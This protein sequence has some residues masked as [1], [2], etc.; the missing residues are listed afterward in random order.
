MPVHRHF[1]GW[2]GP[3]LPRAVDWLVERF[4]AEGMGRVVV[5]LPGGRAA[6]RLEYLL[7]R[8]VIAEHPGW[9]PPWVTRIGEAT[10]ALVP[11]PRRRAGDLERQLAWVEALRT[12]PAERRSALFVAP[13]GDRLEDWLPFAEQVRA[14]HAE[15]VASGLRFADVAERCA[16]DDRF[17][18]EAPRWR[19]L[20]AVQE[21]YAER[22]EAAEVCD[23]HLARLDFLASDAPVA[24]EPRPLV[25][26]GV[27][28]LNALQR[29]IVERAAAA[30]HEVHALVAA[31]EGEAEGFDEL[32]GLRPEV[33]AER[34]LAFPAEDDDPDAVWR[35]ADRPADQAEEVKRFLSHVA[36]D[37]GLHEDRVVVAAEEDEVVPYLE[38]MLEAAGSSLRAPVGRRLGLTPPFLLLEALAR[39]VDGR[40]SED[41]AELLRHPAWAHAPCGP[42]PLAAWDTYLREHAPG[43]VDGFWARPP[44]DDRHAGKARERADA[45]D[46]WYAAWKELLGPLLERDRRPLD[47]W[48]EAVRAFLLA[49]WRE[50]PV[51]ADDSPNET[52]LALRRLRQALDEAAALPAELAGER[53]RAG[54]FLELVLHPLRGVELETTEPPGKGVERLGWLELPLDDTPFL[55]VTGF[56][57]GRV[58]AVVHGHPFLP[59]RFREW[60]GLDDNR[61]RLARD[62]FALAVL[63]HARERLLLVSGRRSRQGDPWLPSP[64]VFQA[65]SPTLDRATAARKRAQ[66]FFAEPSDRHRAAAGGEVSQVEPYVRLLPEPLDAPEPDD[67]H[68]YSASAL[69]LYRRSPVEYWLAKVAQAEELGPDPRELDHMAFGNLVHAV[70]QRFHEAEPEEGLSDPDRVVALLDAELDALAARHFG[71]APM[72]SVRLQVEQARVR[73]HR[74]AEEHCELRR[75]GWRTVAVEWSPPAPNGKGQGWVP[76]RGGFTDDEGRTVQ[77]EARLGGRIDRI[78]LRG[79]EVLVLDYKTG[80]PMKKAEVHAKGKS[81]VDFQPVVYRHLARAHEAVGDGQV[82][83]AWFHLSD[84]LDSMGIQTLE[85]V[86]VEKNKPVPIP[87]EEGD[88]DVARIVHGIRCRRFGELG[89]P[90][91]QETPRTAA[92][93]GRGLLAVA[94]GGGSAE[95]AE[96]NEA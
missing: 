64:L 53:V 14:L 68:V 60:L 74:F 7:T 79:E 24:G 18:R 85:E 42:P 21:A 45:L 48:A 94:E 90:E 47:A 5:A 13:D 38:T 83:F 89:K 36:G 71:R 10:D 59:Q 62:A 22:L 72:P 95:G 40:R 51:L 93:L 17:R 88:E 23:P 55:A 12:L 1:V 78:D 49:T 29:R 82:R 19:A 63:L 67:E 50:A 11:F 20:A 43:T 73:L 27:A 92:F 8:R 70:L 86:F 56:Q 30:G 26:V 41:F 9:E 57:Q 35:A 61:R 15:L 65:R 39:F 52:R 84:D 46:A 54:E 76:F 4:G 80:K 75:Q 91:Y 66:R 87:W 16:A 34:E 31:P 3:V 6:R 81:W 25:L 44:G 37:D 69:K 58:P 28:D 77:V 2:D 33:W 96:E 32:G